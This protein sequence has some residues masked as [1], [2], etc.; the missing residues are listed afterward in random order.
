MKVLDLFSGLG[1]FSAA[2]KERGHEVVT[3]DLDYRFNPTYCRDI[4]SIENI[5]SLGKFDVVLASPPCEKY[6]IAASSFHHWRKERDVYVPNSK[7]AERALKLTSHLFWLLE[8][9]YSGK[10]WVVENP[11]G[12]MR[13]V[14]GKPQYEIDQCQYGLRYRKA[15]D[16]WGK[17]PE[18]FKPKKCT[19]PKECLHIKV[20]HSWEAW[21]HD[22]RA[23][24][25]YS[26]SRN[27][28]GTRNGVTMNYYKRNKFA[29]EVRNPA[30]RALIAPGLSLEVCKAC[31]VA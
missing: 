24:I 29:S 28:L 22:D 13:K 14:F 8:N 26:L 17:L 3:L 27:L 25:P 19:K 1:G 4:M 9:T 21:R 20:S 10:Y 12:Y 30:L 6:S 2:F 18:S 16:F 31:E 5:D 15:T 23:K 7:D 11:R